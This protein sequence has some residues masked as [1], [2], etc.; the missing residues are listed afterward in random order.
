MVV[1]APGE[2]RGRQVLGRLEAPFKDS[3]FDNRLSQTRLF[4]RKTSL[5]GVR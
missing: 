5:N 1:V 2:G 3:M 4:L